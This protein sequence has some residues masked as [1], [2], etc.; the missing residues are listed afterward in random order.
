MKLRI[1][2]GHDLHPLAEGR[3]FLLA[4]VRLPFAK[5]E[6]GHSDGD[7]LAHAVADALLGA[8]AL[9]DIGELFPPADPAWKDADSMDL[10]RNVWERVRSGGWDLVNLDCVVICE[11]PKILPHREEIRRALAAALDVETGAVFV[12]GKTAEALG[13][14]GE[15]LAVGADAVCLLEKI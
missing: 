2:I 10:L 11:G 13:P 5:G 14:L 7:V 3:P 4:G 15:G 9:G 12:K 6:L 1:G 8:A